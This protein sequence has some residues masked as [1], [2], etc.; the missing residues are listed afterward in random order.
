M[1]YIEPKGYFSIVDNKTKLKYTVQSFK[2][3]TNTTYEPLPLSKFCFNLEH[4]FPSSETTHYSS[5]FRQ[6]KH[7][8]KKYF[9]APYLLGQPKDC[10]TRRD[11][12]GILNI[13]YFLVCLS[14]NGGRYISQKKLVEE[15]AKVHH[16][17]V[18]KFKRPTP[19][20]IAH[21]PSKISQKLISS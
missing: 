21:S 2:G 8:L 5:I 7:S 18:R 14:E 3:I 13:I 11:L 6:Y 16:Y 17:V 1:V 10:F 20:A 9:C 12:L 4:Q 19:N 15:I